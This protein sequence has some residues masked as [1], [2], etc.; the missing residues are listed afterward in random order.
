MKVG[1]CLDS[2]VLRVRYWDAG[3]AT[4]LYET[5]YNITRWLSMRLWSRGHQLRSLNM[6]VMLEVYL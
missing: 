4:R 1:M 5:L 6:A 3:I 2:L